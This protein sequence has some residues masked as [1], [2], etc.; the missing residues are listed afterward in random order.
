MFKIITKRFSDLKIF[1][2]TFF[3]LFIFS[4]VSAIDQATIDYMA[5]YMEVRYEVL[6]NLR[7]ELRTFEAQITLTNRG[8]S[9]IKGDPW[10]IYFC[11]IRMI[12]PEHLPDPNGIIRDDVKITHIQG[13]MFTLEP[14][15]SFKTIIPGGSKKIRFLGENWIVSK[16]DIMPNW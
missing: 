7:D 5:T 3:L 4:Q 1:H 11:H 2:W 13:C 15:N 16:T 9:I 8:S 6:D 12:E 10:I 14:T